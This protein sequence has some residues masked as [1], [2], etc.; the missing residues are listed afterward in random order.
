MIAFVPNLSFTRSMAVSSSSFAA[1]SK[2]S[3]SCCAASF[4]RLPTEMPISGLRID[5]Y[6]PLTM[7][8]IAA[9]EVRTEVGT[10]VYRA[11]NTAAFDSIGLLGDC[12]RRSLDPFCIEVTGI[13]P[14]L[15]LPPFPQRETGLKVRMQLR[16]RLSL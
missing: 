4:S 6:S 8:E 9:I 15:H 11:E 14:Q 3:A 7:I 1:L 13:D 5:F 10:L 2:G 12:L 16:V